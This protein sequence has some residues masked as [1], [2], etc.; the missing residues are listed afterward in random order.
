MV[1]VSAVRHT[2]VAEVVAVVGV[3]WRSV[4]LEG[5]RRLLHK[6]HLPSTLR[7]MTAPPL[8]S[9]HVFY[10]ISFTT[11]DAAVIVVLS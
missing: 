1:N 10:E 5:S 8:S 3:E 7:Q 6:I 9:L 2:I 4:H 11:V